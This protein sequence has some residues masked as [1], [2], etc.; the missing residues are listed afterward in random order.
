MPILRRVARPLLAST[1]LV[2]GVES[3]RN[4]SSRVSQAEPV[5]RRI[6]DVL[7]ERA[8]KDL[9]TLVRVN[10]VAQI[11][12]GALL[13]LGRLPRVSA[14]VLAASLLPSTFGGHPFWQESDKVERVNQR[15]HFVKNL[16]VLGGLLIAVGDTA[17]RPSL[18]WRARRAA[19]RTSARVHEVA[20]STST[21]DDH[22]VLRAITRKTP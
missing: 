13:G 5:I 1:F 15:T 14:A 18:G 7:P 22:G 2:G 8:P 17:G 19:D 20:R 10:A 9:E 3:L 11:G 4:P 12:A 16:S 21:V 6:A